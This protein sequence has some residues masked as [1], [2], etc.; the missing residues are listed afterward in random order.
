MCLK[1]IFSEA[2]VNV[3]GLCQMTY[4]LSSLLRYLRKKMAP[5]SPWCNVS[6]DKSKR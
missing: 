4:V 6:I 2:L 3:C 5:T 1:A